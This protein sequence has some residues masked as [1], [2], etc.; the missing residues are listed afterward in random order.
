LFD[1]S[2]ITICVYSLLICLA[3]D[4]QYFA[5]AFDGAVTVTL[6]RWGDPLSRG[7]SSL[8]ARRMLGPGWLEHPPK[9]DLK[10]WCPI[11]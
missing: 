8:P 5:F 1:L 11:A 4:S 2:S 7:R 9:K 3:T 6:S 10:R